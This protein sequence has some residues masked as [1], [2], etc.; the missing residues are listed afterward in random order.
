MT[1]AILCLT[2]ENCLLTNIS[3]ANRLLLH[4]KLQI[5]AVVSLTIGIACIIGHKINSHQPHFTNWH[6]Y[7]G[8]ITSVLIVITIVFGILSKYRD[9]TV[10]GELS[11]QSTVHSI[12]GIVNYAMAL[13]AI[14][15]GMHL[16]IF[17]AHQMFDAIYVM[18][19][20]VCRIGIYGVVNFCVSQ[21]FRRVGYTR[22]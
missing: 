20:F 1:E 15:L 17:H 16:E 8:A 7:F 5:A 2:P 21:F 22:F 14:C 9:C 6:A 13:I 12:L 11:V 3:Y 19:A 10:F 4:W 18:V